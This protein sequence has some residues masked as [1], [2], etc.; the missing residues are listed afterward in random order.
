[1]KNKIL[2]TL[3][4]AGTFAAL[5]LL[6]DPALA[7]SYGGAAGSG[8]GL[9]N[10]TTNLRSTASSV[11][12]IFSLV[13]YVVGV[14][15]GI[16]A[17]LKFKEHNESKGQIPVSQPITLAVVAALLLALPTLMIMIRDS[18]MGTGT[19]NVSIEGGGLNSID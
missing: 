16:K 19:S 18:V 8:A 2:K 15:F 6:A 9:G 11:T 12:D 4:F 14:G 10:L 3:G 5:A 7:A 17:A 13:A 1:M